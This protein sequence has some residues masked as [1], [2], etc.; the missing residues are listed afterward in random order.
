[1]AF[2]KVSKAAL[3]R[4]VDDDIQSVRM[5]GIRTTAARLP[6]KDDYVREVSRLW[7]EAQTRFLTIGQYLIYAKQTLPH[8]EYEA[9]VAS[10]LPFKRAVAHALK[11]VAE[12][13]AAERLKAEELPS[14]Y[15]SAYLL[16]SLSDEKLFQA[17]ERDLVRPDVLRRE[18]EAFRRDLRTTAMAFDRRTLTRE[19]NHLVR[20]IERLQLRLQQV[21]QEL[22]TVEATTQEVLA[23]ATVS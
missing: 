11:T 14:S 9:M 19:R 8:G 12:A 13:V 21:N 4:R 10:E 15:Q 22:G 17:R 18:I 6:E 16:A 5:D 3:A 2:Q 7:Q 20:E 23:D 1:M